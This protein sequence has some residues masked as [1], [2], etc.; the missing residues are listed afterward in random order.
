M[1]VPKYIKEA[2]LKAG[3]YFAL[4]HKYNN[5]A[6]DWLVENNLIDENK[7]DGDNGFDLDEYIDLVEYGGGGQTIIENLENLEVQD[8]KE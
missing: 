8:E 1:K 3:K 5:I 4:A 6:R 7:G 2:I